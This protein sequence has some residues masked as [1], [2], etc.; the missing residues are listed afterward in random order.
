MW[1]YIIAIIVIIIIFSVW[2][3]KSREGLSC[4][5]ERADM[6]L[7]L[8]NGAT[9]QNLPICDETYHGVLPYGHP[10]GPKACRSPMYNPF[11]P[12]YG[13]AGE[14]KNPQGYIDIPISRMIGDHA[15]L[16]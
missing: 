7:A 6:K 13:A 15:I 9:A 3:R 14:F 11:W 8:N 1:K 10:D 4:G 2:W 12:D 16:E 5:C